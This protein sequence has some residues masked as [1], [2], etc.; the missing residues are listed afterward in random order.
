VL[1]IFSSRITNGQRPMVFEDGE[2]LRDFIHVADVARA[3]VLALEK[4]EADGEVFNIGSGKQMTVNQVAQAVARAMGRGE[5]EPEV[6]GK[7]RIGDI[8]HCV[9]DITKA[10]TKLG[11][12]PKQDFGKGLIELAEWVACQEAEDRVP[13]ARRELEARGLVA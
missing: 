10:E 7:M 12:T 6:T 3:F 8:R 5:I 9:P 13:D 11:Y 2:Q 1:A 4:P